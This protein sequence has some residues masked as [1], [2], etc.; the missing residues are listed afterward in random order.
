MGDLEMLETLLLVAQ[1]TVLYISDNLSN[2][3]TLSAAG[4]YDK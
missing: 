3:R 4:F 1:G 2:L